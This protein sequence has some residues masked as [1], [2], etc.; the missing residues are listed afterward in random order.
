MTVTRSDLALY[1][2]SQFSS[3][4]A[5]VGQDSLPEAGFAVDIDLTLRKLGV[6]RSDLP[7]A[8]LA[9]S[10]EEAAQALA[11]YYALLRIWRQLGDRVNRS[12]GK[13]SFSF[14]NQLNS[15]KAML[16]DAKARCQALGYDVSGDAWSISTLNLD[17]LEPEVEAL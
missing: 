13:V 17:W 15:V 4:A 14:T 16:D 10:Q 7:D 6:S 3:L 5:S 12:T 1:L 9:D 2:D 8:T 11:S